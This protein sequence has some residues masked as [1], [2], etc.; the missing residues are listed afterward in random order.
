MPIK[1]PHLALAVVLA[2]AAVLAACGG[3]SPSEPAPGRLA[4][5]AATVSVSG[6]VVNG[7]TVTRG[8]GEGSS[9]RFEARL[10][11]AAGKPAAGHTV[12][13]GYER[14]GGHGAMMGGGNFTLY[15]DGTHGDHVA[16]D[17]LYCY[18]DFAGAYGCHAAGAP[19]GEHHWDF[20]GIDPMGGETNHMRVTV[21]VTEP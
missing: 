21:T 11:D 2:A 10:L 19:L 20:Y 15:D 6:T 8:H 12:H 17:G 18:E 14:P 7:T 4:L 1:R 13:V 16:G 9:T 5:S 3:S